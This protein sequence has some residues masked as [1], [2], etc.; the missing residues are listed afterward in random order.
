MLHDGES[1]CLDARNLKKLEQIKNDAQTSLFSGCRLSKLEA[2]LMLLELEASN[3]L[4]DKGFSDL[5]SIL[6]K[7]L[8]SPMSCLR[9]S[10]IQSR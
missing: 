8:P 1:E 6:E 3:G 7:M 5:L 9:T 2:N 4:S 10:S